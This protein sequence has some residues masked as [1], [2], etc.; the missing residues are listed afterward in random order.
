MTNE[1]ARNSVNANE[2]LF[3]FF[4]AG[5]QADAPFDFFG[6]STN[7]NTQE[8]EKEK[9]EDTVQETTVEEVQTDENTT[10]TTNDTQEPPVTTTEEVPT[11]APEPKQEIEDVKPVE[12]VDSDKKTKPDAEPKKEEKPKRTR[13]RKT[14]T[15]TIG[16]IDSVR[17]PEDP[18]SMEVFSIP[19][20]PKM[21]INSVI[22]GLGVMPEPDFAEEKKDIERKMKEIQLE[23]SLDKA[24][25]A[26]M[27]ERIDELSDMLRSRF[28][29]AKTLYDNIINRDVGIIANVKKLNT[30]GAGTVADKERN[31]IIAL[32]NYSNPGMKDPVN[33]IQLAWAAN[34]QYNFLQSALDQVETKRRIL[35]GIEDA[36][37][38][39]V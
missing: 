9:V 31:S 28:A 3:N 20:D 5:T 24:N 38:G 6:E 27:Y 8:P 15:T 17:N 18:D 22:G 4:D 26:L 12:V 34:Y 39:K 11:E 2:D 32:M 33:L 21:S 10:E 36:V 23:R 30:V 14:E 29:Y 37:V 16:K 35:R 1:E 19:I 7:S 13:R 25:I